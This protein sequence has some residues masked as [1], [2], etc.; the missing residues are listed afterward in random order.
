MTR[1]RF[2]ELL[3]KILDTVW[4]PSRKVESHRK[5]S[6]DENWIVARLKRRPTNHHL[7]EQDATGPNVQRV[8]VAALLQHFWGQVVHSTAERK[9]SLDW[10]CSLDPHT[11]TKVCYFEDII[12]IDKQILWLQITVNDVLRMQIL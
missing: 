11:P 2:H 6:R 7:I 3:D 1:L 4:H 9:P 8:I 12:R 5:N 10:L